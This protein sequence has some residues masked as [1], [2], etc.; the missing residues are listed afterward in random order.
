MKHMY[1]F[2]LLGS[3]SLWA[4]TPP[5]YQ[6]RIYCKT[7]GQNVFQWGQG[8]P[9]KCPNDTSH[10]INIHSIS[11]VDEQ[12]PDV[13]SIK[14]ETIK[15]GGNFRVQS[16]AV[17]A[18][19][20]PNVTSIVEY[21]WPFDISVLA[22]YMAPDAANT[23]DV[24]TVTV[25]KDTVYGIITQ[26]VNS[27]STIIPV[28]ASVVNA[29]A[30]GYYVKLDDGT[31]AD[32][33]GRVIAID[34][35]NNTITVETATTNSFAAADLAQVKVSIRPVDGLELVNGLQYTLGMK[36]IGASFIPANTPITV[37][38]LNKINVPKKLVLTYE[39]LY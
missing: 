14:E 32:D 39:Y 21:S 25:G 1:L 13:M 20:G 26:D 23:G 28:S 4:T 2:L 6:Y 33:L 18:S 30:K 36:K 16:E 34:A 29:I 11:V 10:D 22:I 17:V 12:G 27:G 35:N 3:M 7:E 37:E 38:Y 19:E 8:E 9:T 5:V 31:H 15:T 24:L